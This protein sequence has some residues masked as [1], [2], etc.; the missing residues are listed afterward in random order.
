MDARV[1]T[2]MPNSR[3]LNSIDSKFHGQI[4]WC[5]IDDGLTRIGYVFSQ[6]LLEKYGGIEGVTQ[7]VA[8]KEAIQALEPFELEFVEVHWFTIYVCAVR[9]GACE[10]IFSFRVSA[11]QLRRRLPHTIEFSWPGMRATLTVLDRRRG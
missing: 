5:P 11:K 2:N 10:A 7:E 1:K 6:A 9:C 3:C 8:M 4:L